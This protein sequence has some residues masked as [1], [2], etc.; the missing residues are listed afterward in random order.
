MK[1]LVVLAG[2]RGVNHI[3]QGGYVLFAFGGF[4]MDISDQRTVIELFG[5]YPKILTAFF[6][7]ALGVLNQGIYELQNIRFIMDIRKR[8]IVHRFFEVDRIEYL[9]PIAAAL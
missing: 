8:V 6:A 7:V 3:K 9:Y 1:F 2:F 5:F 4:V